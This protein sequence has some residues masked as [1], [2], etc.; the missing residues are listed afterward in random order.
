MAE[1]EDRQFNSLAERIAALNQQKN[2][3]SSGKRAPPPP[4]PGRPKSEAPTS[5]G[6]TNGTGNG[7]A[8]PLI[9]AQRNPVIPARPQKREQPASVAAAHD[10]RCACDGHA[11]GH[12]PSAAAF[13]H[14]DKHRVF[15]QFA[16]SAPEATIDADSRRPERF[17]CLRHVAY[18][19]HV[20]SLPKPDIISH[21]Y[22]VNR[23]PASSQAAT[24]VRSSEA[25]TTAA[26]TQGTRGRQRGRSTRSWRGCPN[27]VDQVSA[28]GAA[29][30]TI[31]EPTP[32]TSI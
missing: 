29:N 10:E 17:E 13:A 8:K 2:F 19:S 22:H 32:Q 9:P 28:R 18:V 14:A 25:P 24:Y 6:T 1:V 16:S 31:P 21:E 11:P 20:E 12:A 7:S 27:K 26:F 15:A 30:P 5:N 4:P 3:S 23:D